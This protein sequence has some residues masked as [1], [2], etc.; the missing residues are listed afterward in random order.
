M[1]ARAGDAQFPRLFGTVTVVLPSAELP[2]ASLQAIV[3][4]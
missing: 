2:L 1:Q 4:V 3:I